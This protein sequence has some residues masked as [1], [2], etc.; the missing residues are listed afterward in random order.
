MRNRIYII[1][2][3]IIFFVSIPIAHADVGDARYE[4]TDLNISGTKI[5]FKGWGFIHRTH[6]FTEVIDKNGTRVQIAMDQRLRIIHKFKF[7]F[8]R[9]QMKF[10]IVI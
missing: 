9:F 4:I 3:F 8:G 5:T 7:Q 10:F 1:F 6:N 2:V